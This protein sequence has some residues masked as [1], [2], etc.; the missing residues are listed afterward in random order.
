[1]VLETGSVPVTLKSSYEYYVKLVES[2]GTCIL[3]GNNLKLETFQ[4]LLPVCVKHGS[5]SQ[6][7]A[8]FILNGITK[9]FD[10]GVDESLMGHAQV[11]KNYKSA[12][13]NSQLISD[14]LLKRVDAGKTVVLGPWK[15]GDL[16]PSG[17]KGC[18]VPQGGVPKKLEKDVIRPVSDH[19]K[20]ML[21]AS[22]NLSSVA[23]TLD[24]YAE[25]S[26]ELKPGY[27]MRVEDVD[28][29]LYVA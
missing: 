9:G 8:D 10:L 29:A 7:D 14:A 22:M 1:M 2:N 3:P 17:D 23:H 5:V 13:Q 27:F 24:T 25:I 18:N 6:D 21:N 15:N 28:G 11:R 12:L 4:R 26:Q 19:S 16:L 20:T